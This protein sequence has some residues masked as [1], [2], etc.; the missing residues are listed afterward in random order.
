MSINKDS[1]TSMK[2][3]LGPKTHISDAP[4]HLDMIIDGRN[5]ELGHLN[6]LDNH[7]DKAYENKAKPSQMAELLMQCSMQKKQ[8]KKP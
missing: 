6:E 2:F 1:Y 4:N 5:P 8:D 3:L 7:L